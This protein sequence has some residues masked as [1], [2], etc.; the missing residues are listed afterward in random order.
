MGVLYDMRIEPM[1]A[2]NEDVRIAKA[3]A[4]GRLAIEAV[5]GIG[6]AFERLAQDLLARTLQ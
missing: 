3:Y 1:A 6:Q 5:P 4:E 2:F